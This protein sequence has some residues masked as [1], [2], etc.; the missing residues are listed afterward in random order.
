MDDGLRG[1]EHCLLHEGEECVRREDVFKA[2]ADE[3]A[4]LV[5]CAE[6]IDEDEVLIAAPVEFS[7]GIAAD[8]SG[9]ACDHNLPS[10]LPLLLLPDREAASG[11]PMLEFPTTISVR[12][13]LF[14]FGCSAQP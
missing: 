14:I 7:D 5:V 4:P 1:A 8:E 13:T 9:G 2:E 12:A 10:H 11:I 3:V 6:K